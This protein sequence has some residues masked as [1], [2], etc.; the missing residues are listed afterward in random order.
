MKSDLTKSTIFLQA[1]TSIK[2]LEAIKLATLYENRNKKWLKRYCL[3]RFVLRR[4]AT[5]YANWGFLSMMIGSWFSS[6][7]I[8][9]FSSEFD[10]PHMVSMMS[11]DVEL[12]FRFFISFLNYW[13]LGYWIRSTSKNVSS[14]SKF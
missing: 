8:N 4:W 12:S 1:S 7:K 2:L 14:K 3:K 6:M 9:T 13:I 10:F 5:L 11:M